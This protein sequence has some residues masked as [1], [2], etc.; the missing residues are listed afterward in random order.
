LSP[1]F[2]P[3]ARRL[4]SAFPTPWCHEICTTSARKGR[5]WLVILGLRLQ[6]RPGEGNLRLVIALVS[7]IVALASPAVATPTLAPTAT[8]LRPG[9][10]GSEHAVLRWMNAYRFH[11]DVAHVPDAMRALSA[12]GTLKDPGACG[13]YVG[14]FA[15]VL[16]SNPGRFNELVTRS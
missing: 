1:E 6:V 12:L 13:A 8:P 7:A 14:F 16:G 5:R 2:S 3:A 10:L 15:G 9:E 11:H 4:A